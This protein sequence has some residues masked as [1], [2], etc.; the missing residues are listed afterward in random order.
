MVLLLVMSIF[1]ISMWL[2]PLCRNGL[3]SIVA[4]AHNPQQLKTQVEPLA[5]HPRL[6]PRDTHAHNICIYI[7]YAYTNYVYY[8]YINI[9]IYIHIETS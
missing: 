5:L 9:Y 1:F 2:G 6:R 8:I 7:I 4:S 3:T